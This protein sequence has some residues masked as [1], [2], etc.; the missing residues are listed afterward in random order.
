MSWTSPSLSVTDALLDLRAVA[1]DH[2]HQVVGTDDR[3]RRRVRGVQRQAAHAS[4]VR[5]PV[6]GLEVVLHVLHERVADLVGRLPPPGQRLRQERLG[7]RQLIGG[8]CAVL[9][10][11]AQLLA[12]LSTTD[13][14]VL[15]VWTGA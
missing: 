1:D 7:V 6:V 8:E 11:V 13:S 5:V 10:D 12:A 2:P 9:E 14:L 4:R 15:S 3:H